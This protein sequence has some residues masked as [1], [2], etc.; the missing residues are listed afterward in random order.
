VLGCAGFVIRDN[1]APEALE[2]GL[3]AALRNKVD[4]VV[5][6]SANEAYLPAISTIKT[7]QKAGN[8]D[9]LIV[10]AGD[11]SDLPP[12]LQDAG[13]DAFIHRNHHLLET[14]TQFHER[15]GISP[16]G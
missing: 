3:Q 11:P 4:L 9:A 2:E 12:A 5:L 1:P 7:L 10:V 15:L 16:A 14:L 8:S 13:V 6:C